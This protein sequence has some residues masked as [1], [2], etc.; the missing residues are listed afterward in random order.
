MRKNHREAG[1]VTQ[2]SSGKRIDSKAV[3]ATYVQAFP[4][5]YIYMDLSYIY[6]GPVLKNKAGQWCSVPLIKE[7][8]GGQISFEFK[9]SLVY[10]ANSR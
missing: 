3:W 9:A 4:E 6:R 7:T 1:I 5:L 2:G 8:R 10:R